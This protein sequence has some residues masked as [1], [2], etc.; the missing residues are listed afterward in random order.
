MARPYLGGSSAGVKSV[1]SS[2]S[3]AKSDSGK[4]ILLSGAAANVVTLPAP[5]KGMEFK[6][7]LTAT[8]AAPTVVSNASANIMI[9]TV[10]SATNDAAQAIQSDADADTITFVNGGAPGDY[11]DL[12]SDGT[13]WYVF[14]FSGVDSKITITKE[15]A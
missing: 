12:V 1:S 6:I 5:E 11:C 15:S 3:L 10:I 8:G 2:V 4:K 13:S 9:G 7:I 14:G